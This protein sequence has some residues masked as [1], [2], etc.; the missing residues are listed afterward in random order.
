MTSV[1]SPTK[2]INGRY[3]GLNMNIPEIKKLEMGYVPSVESRLKLYDG[4]EIDLNNT[5][6]AKD[7]EWMQHCVEIAEDF[8]SGQGTPG[9]YFYIF[10]PGFESAKK[11]SNRTR[12]Y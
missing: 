8:Q 1:P 3:L 4:I 9:A 10:R 6:W 12:E 11:V 2:D 5:T 7:W